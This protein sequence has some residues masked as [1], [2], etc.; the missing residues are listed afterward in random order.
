[1]GGGSV[2]L[3][4]SDYVNSGKWPQFVINILN[5]TFI[6]I[7]VNQNS[8]KIGQRDLLPLQN[9]NGGQQSFF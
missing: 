7:V 3:G 8:V 1:M 5:V 6:P 2:L 9:Q 4:V